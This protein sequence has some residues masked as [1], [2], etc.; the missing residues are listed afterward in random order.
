MKTKIT[1][2]LLLLLL[3]LVGGKLFAQ[4][5]LNTAPVSYQPSTLGIRIVKIDPLGKLF[6][7]VISPL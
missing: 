6:C 2:I 7:S 4:V 5:Q 1:L 3:P